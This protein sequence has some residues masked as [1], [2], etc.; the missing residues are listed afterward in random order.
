MEIKNLDYLTAF[1][2]HKFFIDF[3]LGR[4]RNSGIVVD[5]DKDIQIYV[6]ITVTT[7]ELEWVRYRYSSN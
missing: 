4:V 6:D 3:M 2:Q 1:A 7:I 5:F